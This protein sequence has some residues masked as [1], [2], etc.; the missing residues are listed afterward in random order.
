VQIW[1]LG[2]HRWAKEVESQL[3]RE[4]YPLSTLSRNNTYTYNHTHAHTNTH[5]CVHTST[6]I[7]I[8]TCMQRHTNSCTHP[9]CIYTRAVHVHTIPELTLT[10][11]RAHMHRPDCRQHFL[12]LPGAP[13]GLGPLLSR[14]Q[15]GSGKEEGVSWLSGNIDSHLFQGSRE[16]RAN[17]NEIINCV[18]LSSIRVSCVTKARGTLPGTVRHHSSPSTDPFI[19]HPHNQS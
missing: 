13:W 5:M 12:W 2:G 6:R 1:Q 15:S 8:Y 19:P 7:H 3:Q 17:E 14:R 10:H 9:P 4:T 16:V 11:T 18:P